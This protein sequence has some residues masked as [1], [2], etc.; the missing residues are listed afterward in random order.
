VDFA[1]KP[2][3]NASFSIDAYGFNP[4]FG[5]FCSKTQCMYS[6]AGCRECFNP[7]FGGFCSK[8]KAE[9]NREIVSTGFNPCF[10]GFCSKTFPQLVQDYD[11]R[12]LFQSLF[13]WILL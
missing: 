4:C 12:L 3:V 6:K 10:G 11:V 1:L 9:R 5:G 13:W 8:T 2:Q 7:C